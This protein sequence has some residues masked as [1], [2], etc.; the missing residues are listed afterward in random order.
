MAEPLP[1]DPEPVLPDVPDEPIEPLEG[2][3]EEDPGVV[4]VEL[5]AALLQP[6]SASA[7]AKASAA[8]VA[9]FSVDACISVFL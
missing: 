8:A 2:L 6:A 1:I 9:V 7:A 3:V 4:V 5:S